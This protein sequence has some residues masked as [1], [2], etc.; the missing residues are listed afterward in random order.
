MKNEKNE[1]QKNE[2]NELSINNTLLLGIVETFASTQY[3][4]MYRVRIKI[5]ATETSLVSL[6]K[7]IVKHIVRKTKP[8]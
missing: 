5:S 7:T 1:L 8:F 6:H 3:T 2:N 4:S